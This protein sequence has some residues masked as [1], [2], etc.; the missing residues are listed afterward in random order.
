MRAKEAPSMTLGATD[1]LFKPAALLR[2]TTVQTFFF[3][4]DFTVGLGLSPSQP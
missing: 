4:P 3:H 1:T 2:R